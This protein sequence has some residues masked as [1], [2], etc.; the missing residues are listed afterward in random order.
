MLCKVL[1]VTGLDQVFP[2]FATVEDALAQHAMA[3]DHAS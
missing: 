2:V 3:K 1:Q